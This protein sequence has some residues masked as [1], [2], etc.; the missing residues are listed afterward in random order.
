MTTIRDIAHSAGVSIG[1][2]SNYLNDPQLVADETRE[3][4]H[5][6]I[7][8]L[9][10]HPRAAARSLKSRQTH[11]IGLVPIIS[12]EDNRSEDPGDNA[13]L[14]L[15]A[16]LNTLAAESG[17]DLLISAATNRAQ[18]IKTYERL[19]GEAQ[20]DGLILTGIRAQD[21]RLVYLAGKEFPFVAYGR[22][23]IM[24]DYAFVDVDGAAGIEEAVNYLAGLGHQRIAYITP[25]EGL[26]C[27][28]QRWEG[29]VRGMEANDLPVRTEYVIEGGFNE[30]AGQM[31]THLLM[32]L[33]QPPTA[34]LTANDI[35]AFGAMRALQIR[36]FQAGKDVS[37]IGF[38]DISLANHWHPS[39]TTI[40]QPFR[41][42]GFSLMQ[43]LFSIL[44]G[45]DRMPQVLLKPTL[46]IRQSTGE[47]TGS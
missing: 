44:S 5:A 28:R 9:D 37:V 6:A 20:V 33:P 43:S 24:A 2:V 47:M 40:S 21:D 14:E 26:M 4:I 1:T 11:R 25:P 3:K 36:G 31:Y 12:P 13:F 30:R 39:L 45:Q 29:Y 16:G 38:D 8:R 23:D 46:V 41:K 7:E 22:S 32:D 18:E 34:I 35:C 15:L 27:T 17:Y 10:Y 42:I 19:I